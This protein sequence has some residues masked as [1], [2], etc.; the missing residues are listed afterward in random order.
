MDELFTPVSTTYFKPQG[1]TEP[2]LTEVA[3]EAPVTA[4]NRLRTISSPDDALDILKNQPDYD[5][6][7]LVLRFLNDNGRQVSGPKS[8]GIVNLLVSEIA[9]NYWTLLKEGSSNSDGQ[10]EDADL[11]LGYLRRATGLN[12]VITQV[13][14]LIQEARAGG[15]E[16][17]RAD[18]SLNLK[19][20]ADLLA[21]ILVGHETVSKIWLS[22]TEAL[23]NAS[24]KKAQSQKLASLLSNGQIISI[25]AEALSLMERDALPPGSQ[26][27]ADG[28][29]YSEWLGQ[30]I[31]VWAKG[32]PQG[33]E[34]NFCSE[35]LQRALSLNHSGEAQQTK[36]AEPY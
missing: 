11:F 9:P 33:E 12:A 22:S 17:K 15:K 6:L 10:A 7:V 2:L 27:I 8:A 34:L 35:L 19:I 29:A 13:K 1:Q 25:S 14:V 18:V 24:V 21:S 26:W 32:L 30:S 23:P 3:S 36:V 16:V 4:D 31:A 20:L 28:V 5:A